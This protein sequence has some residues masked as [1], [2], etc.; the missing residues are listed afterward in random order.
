MTPK[1]RGWNIKSKAMVDCKE[2]TPLALSAEI[3]KSD[4]D[5]LF[6]PFHPDVILEQFIGL[7]DKNGKEI[8]EG[9]IVR[10][11]AHLQNGAFLKHGEGYYTGVVEWNQ[12]CCC[13][14][15]AGFFAP[16]IDMS[17]IE[18]IGNIHSSPELLKETQ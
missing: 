12:S 6:L 10:V 5:G 11:W 16:N 9:D 14:A 15:F 8:Y 13:Y 1:Y 3:N 17:K 18:I 4:M 2:V 7:T